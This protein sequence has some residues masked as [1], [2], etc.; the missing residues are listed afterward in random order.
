MGTAIAY[1]MN[2]MGY[3]LYV[4]DRDIN[5]LNKNI[6]GLEI[7]NYLLE[8][9][10]DLKT[11]VTRLLSNKPDVVIS[12]LPYHQTEI[13]AD[14]CIDNGIRYCDLG[15]SVPVS[16]NINYSAYKRATTP[17]MTDLGLAPG[18]INILAEQGFQQLG[19]ADEVS[20]MVGGLPLAQD[21]NPLNYTVTWSIDGLINE[22]R[23]DC[24]VLINGKIETVYGMDGLLP[25]QFIDRYISDSLGELEA[26]YTSGGSSH[27]INTMQDRGVRY[28]SYKTLRYPGHCKLVKFLMDRCELP[29]DCLRHIF[30]KGCADNY[31]HGV[32][33][34]DLVILKAVAEKGDLSWNKEILVK[35]DK[36]S[37]EDPKNFTAMQ[38]ATAFPI[39]SVADIMARGLLDRDFGLDRRLNYSHIPYEEFNTT[40]NKLL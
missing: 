5:I 17:V 27:T 20:M 36:G 23:D 29:E 25:V 8:A 26:F 4:I 11:K 28:C 14:F 30:E 3:S 12:A 18:W 31:H 13:V 33:R 6:G 15:G 34:R 24:E 32:D 22:Y 10:D 37:F 21:N 40:L 7:K 39:A 38:K 9:T 19:G 1:A 2:R 16:N 35:A